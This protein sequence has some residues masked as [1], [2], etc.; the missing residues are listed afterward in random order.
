[1]AAKFKASSEKEA[2]TRW[3]VCVEIISVVLTLTI[4]S[5]KWLVSLCKGVGNEAVILVDEGQ[6]GLRVSRYPKVFNK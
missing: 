5:T 3:L 4:L 1:M 6:R 2:M